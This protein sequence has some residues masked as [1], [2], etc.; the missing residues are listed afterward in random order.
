MDFSTV[1]VP[2]P[3]G[4][5]PLPEIRKMAE[6][7]F[8]EILK[9]A[10]DWQPTD[11]AGLALKTPYPS[12]I[13]KFSGTEVDVNDLFFKN[14]WSLG[15]P[16]IPPTPDRVQAMLKGTSRKPDEVV[17]IIAP[18]MG[19]VTVEL[20]AVH[21]VMAGCR[22]EYLPVLLA[23][24]EALCKPEYRGPTTT[25]N[26]TAPFIVV[27]G[28]I[29]DQIG[30]AY[31]QGAGGPGWLPNVT[32]GIA[33]NSIGDVI[34]GS[35]SPS[36]DMTTLGWPGNTIAMVIGENEKAN[37]WG[38]Y[39]VEKGFKQG[40]SVAHV[41]L[42][43]E[44]P[45]NINDH[46]SVKGEDLLRVMAYDMRRAGQNTRF[47]HDSDVMLIISPEHAATAFN[48]GWKDKNTIRKFLWE[49]ARNPLKALPGGGVY[50]KFGPEAAA[51]L[52]GQPVNLETPIP[53]VSG[54]ADIQ[55]IVSGGVGKHSVYLSSSSQSRR[56]FSIS[57]D[58]WR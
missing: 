4:M 49:N 47:F 45:S 28:P 13:I 36:P 56:I 51:K 8:P 9:A 33:V 3:M 14:G 44:I 29:L 15:V 50:A 40:E 24:T 37:P 54:P 32:L 41:M 22:P 27:N 19:V 35:K 46:D 43:G 21:A 34:G 11:G 58:K 7:A 18:R 1:I 10:T 42:A 5:I 23:I 2:H 30:L 25:T 17:G 55:I 26:P 31:G 20:V 12:E 6:N 39:H 57:I 16:I 52:L 53:M 38:P 48:D